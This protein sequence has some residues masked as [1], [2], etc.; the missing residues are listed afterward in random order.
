[1]AD[2]HAPSN[3][4]SPPVFNRILVV[5]VG[6][7]CRSPTAE[8][9]LLHRH[10]QRGYRI[11]SAGLGA[12]KGAPMDP[13][14]LAVLQEH[15]LDHAGHVARQLTGELLAGADLVLVMEKAHLHT[16][17]TR[18]PQASGKTMLLGKWLGDIDIPDPYR[19]QRPAFEHAFQLID[20]AVTSWDRYLP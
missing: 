3:R 6:N 1:M 18:H 9:L 16:I 13:T 11:G 2:S 4:T 12:V 19:Q 20:K 14:A 15:G 7:I 10:A 5:C 8:A 17:Q